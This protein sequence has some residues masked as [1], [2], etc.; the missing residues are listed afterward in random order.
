MGAITGWT[1]DASYV[2]HGY[3]RY[4]DGSFTEFDAPGAGATYGHYQGTQ[5]N[6][7]NLWGAIVGYYTDANFVSTGWRKACP[8]GSTYTLQHGENLEGSK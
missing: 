5:P 1:V 3:V 4:H 8:V 7:I 2:M 6:A